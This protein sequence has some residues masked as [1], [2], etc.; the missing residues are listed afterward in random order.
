M[1]DY[2]LLM[3]H[4]FVCKQTRNTMYAHLNTVIKYLLIN[5]HLRNKSLKCAM[6][7]AF[8][9]MYCLYDL[10]LYTSQ[11]KNINVPG[12]IVKYSNCSLLL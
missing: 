9:N 11:T 1:F 6:A 5:N 10:L 7:C 2:Q 8:C 3:Q 12:Y 4:A